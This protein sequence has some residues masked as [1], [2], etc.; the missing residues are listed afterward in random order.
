MNQG[1]VQSTSQQVR[2][3]K[4]P[5]RGGLALRGEACLPTGRLWDFS[6]F[7]GRAKK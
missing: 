1:D 7:F 5:A 4:N 6:P 3:P 2:K